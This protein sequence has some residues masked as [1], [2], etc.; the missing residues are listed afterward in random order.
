MK[1]S[2]T[3]TEQVMFIQCHVF[4]A[5]CELYSEQYSH[6]LHIVNHLVL[7]SMFDVY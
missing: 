1:A 6:P 4:I 2:V 3:V 5:V 7:C